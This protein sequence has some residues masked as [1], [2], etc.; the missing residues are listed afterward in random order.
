MYCKQNYSQ[1]LEEGAS[2]LG[3]ETQHFT[4]KKVRSL[5]GESVIR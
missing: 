3:D 5:Q 2:G 1:E 4:H